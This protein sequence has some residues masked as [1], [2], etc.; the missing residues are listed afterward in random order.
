MDRRLVAA[1]IPILVL[2]FTLATR[3]SRADA[4]LALPG[5]R[6][7]TCE[8]AAAAALQYAHSSNRRY[9]S[10]GVILPLVAGGFTYTEP[11]GG[12]RVSHVRTAIPPLAVA[13]FHTHTGRM[14]FIGKSHRVEGHSVKDK[15]IVEARDP[16]HRPSFTSHRR[17]KLWR[18]GRCSEERFC[19]REVRTTTHWDR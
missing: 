10:G 19:D 18:Y 11:A 7:A 13:H 3:D 16:L 15:E 17:G 14:K 12:D 2:G 9:E 4:A 1:A 6:F 5:T 8:E